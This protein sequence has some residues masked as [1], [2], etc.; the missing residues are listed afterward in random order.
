[1]RL[2]SQAQTNREIADSLCVAESTVK[3]HVSAIKTKLPG[4][5]PDSKPSSAPTSSGCNPGL[6]AAANCSLHW[7]R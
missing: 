6:S 1:M 5:P 7:P 3:T 4:P 2:L